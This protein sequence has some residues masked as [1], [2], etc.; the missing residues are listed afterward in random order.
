MLHINVKKAVVDSIPICWIAIML[1]I[2]S[3]NNLSEDTTAA[4]VVGPAVLLLA[5]TWA[6]RWIRSKIQTANQELEDVFTSLSS[7]AFGC[8]WQNSHG[9]NKH[10]SVLLYL[11]PN[12][13]LNYDWLNSH[14]SSKHK[15]V[16]LHIVPNA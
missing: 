3:A 12:T 13:G 9:R 6:Y 8:D 15:S 16:I 14:D 11:L 7:F 4:L 5:L 2:A 10:K 1:I